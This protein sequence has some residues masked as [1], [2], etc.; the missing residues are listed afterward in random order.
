MASIVKLM[1][2]VPRQ[3]ETIEARPCFAIQPPWNLVN[4]AAIVPATLLTV[5]RPL[6]VTIQRRYPH[7]QQMPLLMNN[8]FVQSVITHIPQSIPQAF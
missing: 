6:R 3:T 4:L 2:R 7:D 1:I 8:K 5:L